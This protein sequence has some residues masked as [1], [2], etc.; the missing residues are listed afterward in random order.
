MAAQPIPQYRKQGKG[1]FAELNRADG[2]TAKAGTQYG[3][4]GVPINA[5]ANDTVT[6]RGQ[7][8]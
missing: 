6:G 7:T 1:I 5:K 3:Y 4:G 2:V 8:P